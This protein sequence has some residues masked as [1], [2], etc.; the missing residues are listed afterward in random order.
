MRLIDAEELLEC[1]DSVEG[2]EDLEDVIN[3][4]P[5][6]YDVEAVLDQIK[7]L[8]ENEFRYAIVVGIIKGN[9]LQ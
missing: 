4:Q 5:T 9:I 8:N 7:E 3:E 1:I 6:A 2:D